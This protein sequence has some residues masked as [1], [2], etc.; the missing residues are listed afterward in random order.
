MTIQAIVFDIGDVLEINADTGWKA[1]WETHLSLNLTDIFAR[2][3]NSGLDGR[4]GT[5]SE[6]EWLEGLRQFSGMDQTQT[7]ALMDDFWTWYVGQPNT[8]L[9]DYFASL[10]SS[11]KTAILSNSFL[12]ARAREQAR[13]GFEDMT[14]LIVYSHEVGLAKPDPKIYAL[15]CERLGAQPAEIVFL[16]DLESNIAGAKAFG[17]HAV[18][19][20]NNAQSIAEIQNYLEDA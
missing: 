16:D 12:G 20:Q 18:L 17:M 15:T 14:D 8:E 2:I 3:E 5:C 9:I 19:F 7:D 10:R 13:Y 6:A 11:Y 4:L 1:K